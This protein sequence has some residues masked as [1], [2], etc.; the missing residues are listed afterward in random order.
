VVQDAV[1]HDPNVVAAIGEE[2]QVCNVA[3]APDAIMVTMKTTAPVV[4]ARSPFTWAWPVDEYGAPAIDGDA[5][6]RPPLQYFQLQ[7]D[8]DVKLRTIIPVLGET[9]EPS[10]LRG[11]GT[12]PGQHVVV[13]LAN[14]RRA[15]Q[16]LRRRSHDYHRGLSREHPAQRTGYSR[17]TDH[18]RLQGPRPAKPAWRTQYVDPGGGR[19]IRAVSC[20]R[21]RR[22]S[23]PCRP[24]WRTARRERQRMLRL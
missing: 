14:P 21:T 3:G 24:H 6:I 8:T 16:A 17:T 4:V 7:L 5:S 10:A 1:R 19:A 20:S 13:V 2:F 23:R 15:R 22:T 12:S 18:V 9:V 11:L